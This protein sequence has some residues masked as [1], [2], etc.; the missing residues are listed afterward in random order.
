MNLIAI[1]RDFVMGTVNGIDGKLEAPKKWGYLCTHCL[2]S[3]PFG[4]LGW[5][6]RCT[7]KPTLSWNQQSL[8]SSVLKQ[9][10]RTKPPGICKQDMDKTDLEHHT[11]THLSG[12]LRASAV[13]NQLRALPISSTL[14]FYF[15]FWADLHHCGPHEWLQWPAEV[16]I[17][18]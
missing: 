11:V 3:F 14:N 2:H 12:T 7:L 1:C 17:H 5:I 16:S 9:P 6:L 8:N 18:E 4:K 15:N 13:G 10:P